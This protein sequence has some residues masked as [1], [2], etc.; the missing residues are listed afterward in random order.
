VSTR[1]GACSEHGA[2]KERSD[3][4]VSPP[5]KR[6]D[7]SRVFFVRAHPAAV[8]TDFVFAIFVSRAADAHD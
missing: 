1:T 8:P 5:N 6:P 4:P 3:V 7:L 2:T